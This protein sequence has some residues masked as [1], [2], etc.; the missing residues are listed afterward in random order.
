MSGNLVLRP[1]SVSWSVAE[2]VR[3]SLKE[4]SVLWT[5]EVGWS[6]GESTL[7]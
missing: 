4:M 2:L 5:S 1:R 6:S 7:V 3:A